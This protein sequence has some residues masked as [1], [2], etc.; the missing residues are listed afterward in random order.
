MGLNAIVKNIP[1]NRQASMLPLLL[2]KYNPDILIITGHDAMLKNGAN[3]N[4]IYN[5]RNSRHFVNSV[6]EARKWARSSDKLVIFARSVSE[7][8]RSN[9]G[10]W[11]RFCIFTSKN[12]N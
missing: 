9:Y 3:Y 10:G 7:F 4:N 1:E 11:S 2:N 12:F 6:K 8:F 5:Y